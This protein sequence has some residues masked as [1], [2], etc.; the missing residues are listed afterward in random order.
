VAV[1]GYA[2]SKSASEVKLLRAQNT[3]LTAREGYLARREA[4]LQATID[5]GEFG[6]Q[7]LGQWT[8]CPDGCRQ[9]VGG[10]YVQPIPDTFDMKISFQSSG[11]VIVEIVA[12]DQWVRYVRTGHATVVK[13]YGPTQNLNEVEFSSAEGCGGYFVLFYFPQG[14]TIVPDV[15]VRYNPLP[16]SGDC[17][18]H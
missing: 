9:P 5:A 2:T 12:Y 1:L 13:V 15:R 7:W 17:I 6:G 4:D 3:T 14:G 18:K 10:A 11:P 16:G 8:G